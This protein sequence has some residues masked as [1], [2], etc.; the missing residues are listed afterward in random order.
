MFFVFSQLKQKAL[1]QNNDAITYRFVFPL[2][3]LEPFHRYHEQVRS[4][5]QD[6]F[7]EID[8]S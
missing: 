7:I 3:N 2:G 1:F 4:D 6:I 5:F 8:A